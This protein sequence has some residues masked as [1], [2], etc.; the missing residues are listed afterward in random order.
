MAGIVAV[1]STRA[2]HLESTG[3]VQE[4]T[5]VSRTASGLKVVFGETGLQYQMA[6]HRPVHAQMGFNDTF[7]KNG[8]R[9]MKRSRITAQ[10]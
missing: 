10:L 5:H 8:D 2:Q 1:R 9:I 3:E 4:E 6:T 7:V